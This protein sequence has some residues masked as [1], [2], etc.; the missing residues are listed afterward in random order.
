[1]DRSR[2]GCNR[3]GVMVFDAVRK[4]QGV[5]YFCLDRPPST[6]TSPLFVGHPDRAMKHRPCI[7]VAGIEEIENLTCKVECASRIKRLCVESADM[8]LTFSLPWCDHL[9]EWLGSRREVVGTVHSLLVIIDVH[10]RHPLSIERGA[11]LRL[12]LGLP[13]EISVQIKHIVIRSSTWPWFLVFPGF[14]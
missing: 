11:C 10:V 4:C 7:S 3:C 6:S 1:M 9:M 8:L 5:A 2:N 13:C 14:P 12:D